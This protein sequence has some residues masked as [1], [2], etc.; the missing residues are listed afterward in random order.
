[1]P[2]SPP[3]PSILHGWQA[4]DRSDTWTPG[5]TLLCAHHYWQQFL[6]TTPQG[7][8]GHSPHF[9]DEETKASG[10]ETRPR[11][12]KTEISLDVEPGPSKA[13][14]K[15]VWPSAQRLY[16]ITRSAGIPA[17][18][19]GLPEVSPT[20]QTRLSACSADPLLPGEETVF[21]PR[22]GLPAHPSPASNW[23][24]SS[25]LLPAQGLRK[26]RGAPGW[27]SRLS[28]RLRLGS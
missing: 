7:G 14:S 9:I 15:A 20:R 10:E 17:R 19:G 28:G 13:D 25:P 27:L 8:P 23:V 2:N 4:S 26:H 11:S 12:P 24:L 16:P 22:P 5:Q 1:M 6:H 21:C 3:L 18:P